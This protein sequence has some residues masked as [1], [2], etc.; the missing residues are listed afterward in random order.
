M[1]IPGLELYLASASKDLE[2]C[3]EDV[4]PTVVGGFYPP[5]SACPSQVPAFRDSPAYTGA[6]NAATGEGQPILQAWQG[7]TEAALVG[8]HLPEG[9]A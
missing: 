8:S 1:L 5:P 9:D 7:A 4:S 6:Y 2:A 3:W